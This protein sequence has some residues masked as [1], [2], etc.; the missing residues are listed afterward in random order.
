MRVEIYVLCVFSVSYSEFL[1]LFVCFKNANWFKVFVSVSRSVCLCLCL[2]LQDILFLQ[3]WPTSDNKPRLLWDQG[4][5]GS[6]RWG[7][8]LDFTV[9]GSVIR[10]I[11]V[12][13]IIITNFIM[14]HGHHNHDLPAGRNHHQHQKH[15]H[16]QSSSSPSLI[17]IM[18]YLT[19][20]PASII[21]SIGLSIEYCE[22][23][24]FDI[25]LN[26][27]LN[28]K[29]VYGSIPS[30]QKSRPTGALNWYFT[31]LSCAN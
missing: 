9:A 25:A 15:H 24:G 4:V 2:Y 10:I 12:I 21:V 30:E 13:M 1:C 3:W 23:F 29:R 31:L 14:N 5:G 27:D 26:E 16:H 28:L 18:F 19:D 8:H 17:I 22:C 7:R 20:P 6:E 11:V